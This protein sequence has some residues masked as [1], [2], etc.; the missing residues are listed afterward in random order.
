MAMGR[1]PLKVSERR[2][3]I[4]RIRLSPAERKQLDA[5][6]RS[7]GLDTSTWARQQL[8]AVEEVKVMPGQ[9]RPERWRSGQ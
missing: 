8:L 7:N 6:A 3:N 1:P 4:L 9:R 5:A 2:A